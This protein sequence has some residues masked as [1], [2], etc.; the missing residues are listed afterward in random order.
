MREAGTTHAVMFV[1]VFIFCGE[2]HLVVAI[3]KRI[4]SGTIIRAQV[5]L[6]PIH[7]GIN[8]EII[9]LRIGSNVVEVF[10]LD[11]QLLMLIG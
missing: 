2:L 10:Q 5:E 7:L 11:Q 9:I 8:T 3:K 4:S 6:V 1:I